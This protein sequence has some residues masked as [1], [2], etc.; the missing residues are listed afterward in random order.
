MSIK[1]IDPVDN[2]IADFPKE[3]KELLEQIRSAIRKAA[4][5][6]EEVISYQMPAYKFHGMIAWFAGHKNHI[7]FYPGA[8][9]IENF[10]KEIS[11]Y[12]WAKGSVQFPN[13]KPLPVALVTKIVKFRVK[14]N[15]DKLQK[16]SILKKKKEGK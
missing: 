14:E 12:K 6:A 9:G 1:K 7:G 4:P 11:K 10:K 2:Y 8:S 15:L 5:D 3:I 16:K 13:D